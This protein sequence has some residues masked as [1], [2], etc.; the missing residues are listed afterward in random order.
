[1][2]TQILSFAHAHLSKS[3]GNAAAPDINPAIAPAPG[4]P[5]LVESTKT[6]PSSHMGALVTGFEDYINSKKVTFDEHTGENAQRAWEFY[7][8]DDPA[9]TAVLSIQ[10][11]SGALGWTPSDTVYNDAQKSWFTEFSTYAGRVS[12]EMNKACKA[13]TE[14]ASLSI[15]GTTPSNAF[16][17]AFLSRAVKDGAG[18]LNVAAVL[19]EATPNPGA[20]ALTD[21]VS[22]LHTINSMGTVM[23]K[24]VSSVYFHGTVTGGWNT[25]LGGNPVDFPARLASVKM[26][27]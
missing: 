20:G 23:K 22:G 19:N 16:I 7:V 27:F 4:D 11:A 6:A 17:K 15:V 8:V 10:P 24:Y 21:N 2:S 14:A 25:G 13:I 3:L 18:G 1:M 5:F 9:K 26:E 12:G